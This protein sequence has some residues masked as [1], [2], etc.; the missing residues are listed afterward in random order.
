VSRHLK[1][2]LLALA[3]FLACMVAAVLVVYVYWYFMSWEY[4]HT[5]RESPSDPHDAAAMM[6]IA[7]ETLFGLPAGV[8]AGVAA[9]A[10]VIWRRWRGPESTQPAHRSL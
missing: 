1:T 6:L 2:A 9:A 10:L 3:A 5:P 7:L 4:N 8:L